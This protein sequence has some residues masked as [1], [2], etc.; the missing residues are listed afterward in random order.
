[1]AQVAKDA[2]GNGASNGDEPAAPPKP[3]PRRRKRAVMDAA[4]I[5]L[6]PKKGED[7]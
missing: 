4:S 3:R 5:G 2:K 7:G 6:P 1:M